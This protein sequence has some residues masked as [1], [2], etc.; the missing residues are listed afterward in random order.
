MNLEKVW[1]YHLQVEARKTKS[2]SLPEGGAVELSQG[3]KSIFEPAFLGTEKRTPL[4]QPFHFNLGGQ[5][6]ANVMRDNIITLLGTDQGKADKCCEGLA[7]ELQN[8]IDDRVGDL[9]FTVGTGQEADQRRCVLWVYPS[10]NSIRYYERQ[11]KPMVEELRKAFSRKSSYRKA[12]FF[13]GPAA[14]TRNDFLRGEIVDATQGFKSAAHY[15]VE[16]FL[17]GYIELRPAQGAAF[18]AKGLVAAQKKASTPEE[19]NSVLA[20]YSSLLSGAQPNTTLQRF[21]N[22]LVGAAK[23]AFLAVVPSTIE[24]SA[25]FDLSLP[26]IRK[27]ISRL[28]LVLVNGIQVTFPTDES[29]DPSDYLHERGGEQFVR[30]DLAVQSRRYD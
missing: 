8:L 30:L 28:V 26:E 18:L 13:D 11:G 22:T 5:I 1:V 6:R 10:D 14:V 7:V 29:V 21:S 23:E 25:V 17:R 27:R 19:R 2:K 12:A 4:R 9:L 24:R 20:G 16:S 3:I 15:W